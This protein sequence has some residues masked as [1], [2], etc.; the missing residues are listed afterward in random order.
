L[1]DRI[2]DFESG[3]RKLIIDFVGIPVL[4]FW[5]GLSLGPFGII[6]SGE[7]ATL[8]Y[9]I[10]AFFLLSGFWGILVTYFGIRWLMR[11]EARA[12]FGPPRRVVIML[13]AGVWCVLY[14]I[15]FFSSR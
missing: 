4:F 15:F 12:A 2:Q 5:C 9:W 13:Y 6:S 14:L 3:A 11:G 10:S 1:P 7:V 8:R